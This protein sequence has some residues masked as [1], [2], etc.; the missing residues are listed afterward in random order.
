M[1]PG[2]QFIFLCE[3]KMAESIDKPITRAGG[4]IIDRDI[5][6]YGVVITMRKK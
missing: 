4:T 1:L 5:R 2:E 6:S 3:S